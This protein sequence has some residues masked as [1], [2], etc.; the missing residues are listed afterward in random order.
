[1]KIIPYG[2]QFIDKKDIASVLEALKKDIIT[3]GS[4]VEKFENALG[5]ILT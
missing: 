3:T 2:K 1:M 4:T 5:D